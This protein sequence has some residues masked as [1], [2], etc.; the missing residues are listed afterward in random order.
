VTISICL[1]TGCDFFPSSPLPTRAPHA[2]PPWCF[3]GVCGL[4][5]GDVGQ[6][7][8]VGIR[9]I[10][11]TNEKGVEMPKNSRQFKLSCTPG[12]CPRTS[13]AA[14]CLSLR[15]CGVI[16]GVRGKVPFGRLVD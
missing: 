3:Q 13:T 9:V 6:A 12:V 1:T 14:A 8:G 7:R 2:R 16:I 5:D 11:A 10:A 4:R 15:P